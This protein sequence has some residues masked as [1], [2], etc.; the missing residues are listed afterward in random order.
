M[1]VPIG[2]E[3]EQRDKQRRK[4]TNCEIQNDRLVK[5]ISKLS[6][7]KLGLAQY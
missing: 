7:D 6:C 5:A 3:K 2:K 4:Q 1:N